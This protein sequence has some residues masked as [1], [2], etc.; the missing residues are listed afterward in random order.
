MCALSFPTDLSLYEQ[1]HTLIAFSNRLGGFSIGEFGELNLSYDVGDDTNIVKRNRDIFINAIQLSVDNKAKLQSLINPIQVHE[2]LCLSAQEYKREG[3]RFECDAIFCNEKLQ[4]VMLLFA[5]CVP[6]I[7]V[8]ESGNFVV[9]HSGWRGCYNEVS[10]HALAKF[11]SFENSDICEFNFYIGPHICSRCFET[12]S[13]VASKFSDKFGTDVL[14]SKTNVDLCGVIKHTLIS[15]GATNERIACS[16]D[17]TVC[18]NNLYF[19]YRAQNQV[20]GRQ[21][22]FGVCL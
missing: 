11:M 7:A 13:D 3:T 12:S 22:A 10:K 19:S 16:S 6:V 18:K 20:C 17:C 14:L 4:P 1:T 15:L 8:A 5:D 2:T 21:C 9:I